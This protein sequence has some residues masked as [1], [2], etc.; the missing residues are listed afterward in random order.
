M[1]IFFLLP[2]KDRQLIYTGRGV[3]NPR[4]TDKMT[5]NDLDR[6]LE[7][8]LAGKEISVTLTNPLG[9]NVKWEN[10]EEHWMPAEAC[11]LIIDTA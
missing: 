11:D 10:Q 4:E 1:F 2:N 3:D 7:E 9:C 5:V 8:H 6:A